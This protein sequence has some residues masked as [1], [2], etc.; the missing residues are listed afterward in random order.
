MNRNKKRIIAGAAIG[1]A[2]AGI[3]AGSIFGVKQWQSGQWDNKIVVSKDEQK[4]EQNIIL[5]YR[6]DGEDTPHVYYENVD[7]NGTQTISYPGIPMKNTGDGWYT[8]TIA[9]AK[10][11]DIVFSIADTYE[12]TTLR[13]TAGEWWFDQDTWYAEN[14]DA[15]QTE[16]ELADAVETET[17]EQEKAKKE[18]KTDTKYS[19]ENVTTVLKDGTTKVGLSKISNVKEYIE[20]YVETQ[21]LDAAED[22]TITVH[23]YAKDGE[24][25]SIYFWNALPQNQETVWPGQPMTFES[26]NWY[27]YSFS[28]ASKI[29]FL[30]TYGLQQSKDLTRKTGEWWYKDGKWY[31]KKPAEYQEI[32][33]PI[34]S[35]KGDFREETIYF[36]MTTRFY[37]GDESNN[38]HCWD[39]NAKTPED[40]PAWRGDFK[41]LIEKLDYIK[42]LGFSAI[43][44][45]PVVENCSGLDYHGYHAINFQKVDPRYESDGVTYQTLINAA[46]SK[47]LK[48][49]QDVVFNHTGNFGEENIAPLFTK[50]GD[51]EGGYGTINCLKLAEGSKITDDYDSLKPGDQYG[52]RLALLKDTKDPIVPGVRNDPK[53]FYH[54]YG[55]GFNWDFYTVQLG[56]MAGDCVDLNTEN[57]IVAKYLMDSYTKYINMGVDAFR[58][59]TMKH[60]SRL[61][62]NNFLT[63]VL[64]AAGGKDFYMFGEVCT[65]SSQVWY[66]GETPALSG[67]FYTW[68]ESKD[69][70]WVYYDEAVEAEYDEYAATP[71]EKI[72]SDFPTDQEYFDWRL[73]SEANLAHGVNMKSTEENYND[74]ANDVGG[75]SVKA[76]GTAQS[77]QP[78]SDNAFLRGN[79]Y[80]KPDTSMQSGTNVID[81]TMHWNFRTAK[82]AFESVTG[83]YDYET[84]EVGSNVSAGGDYAY[85]DSTWNVTYVDS[86]DYSPD[87]N[88]E[89]RYDGTEEEWA[90]NLCLLFSFRGIPCIY[91]G[92]EIQ[93]QSGKKID[94]GETLALINS[95]RAYYGEHLEGEVEATGFGTYTASG[96][97]KN[98]LESPLSQHI[99]RLNKI[100]RAIPALQKGQYSRAN[101]TS[102]G[103]GMAFKRRYTDDK[104]DSYVLVTITGGAEFTDVLNGTYVDAITG[105]EV[106][107][108]DNKLS[109]AAPGKGNMRIYVLDTELTSAPGKVGE[110]TSYLK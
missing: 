99:I 84:G 19:K 36:L 81:F 9:D 2:T 52:Q 100:R 108:T 51:V 12:T 58:I 72:Y 65:K 45:T 8:Y 17:G 87:G 29:N 109:I 80:H 91:Y 37:D 27:T 11:A 103:E 75:Q 15:E 76:A 63:P 35:E 38:V 28:D 92:S 60:I 32:E 88:F 42:A 86:H 20:T 77:E 22:A 83:N 69:Y 23:Y 68:K 44:I 21:D 89:Y 14:P 5:H 7:G 98:T 79:E 96:E 101:I 97:V 57:P 67:A 46:H 48:I 62:F 16:I 93:F 24:V 78:V 73:E 53:T 25:P 33:T 107:V 18:E 43:W 10:S 74:N 105:E 49:V 3:V 47:G 26:E 1:A 4:E 94:G 110:D 70:D 34:D 31:S 50:D 82:K 54:R 95:G 104:T 13:R 90:E 59:D 41:G 6:W 40:D 56:Q 39:E 64:Q 102:N 85:N 106:T 71:P 61:T 55:T 66:R 30:F